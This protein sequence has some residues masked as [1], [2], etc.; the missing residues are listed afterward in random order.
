MSRY[1][2]EGKNFVAS[3]VLTLA[4]HDGFSLRAVVLQTAGVRYWL[5]ALTC[6]DCC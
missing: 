4:H 3:R 6:F 2:A 1:K 5:P